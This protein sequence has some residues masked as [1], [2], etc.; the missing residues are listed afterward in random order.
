LKYLQLFTGP[1][2]SSLLYNLLDSGQI[3]QSVN[4]LKQIR[5]YVLAY[6]L[7]IHPK[8]C[9]VGY[10]NFV[11]CE[12]LIRIINPIAPVVALKTDIT[13]SLSAVPSATV[14]RNHALFPNV[15]I[16]DL[17]DFGFGIKLR[18]FLSILRSLSFLARSGFIV[19]LTSDRKH[20]KVRRILFWQIQS[21]QNSAV[22]Q[23][24]CK[25]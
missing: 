12:V 24:F 21:V 13:S 14:P 2:A 11:R 3:E 15:R 18:I 20:T 9:W 23:H 17:S 6:H 25:Y 4:H 10:V 16:F 8:R 7:S 19:F 5:F 1:K 22:Y